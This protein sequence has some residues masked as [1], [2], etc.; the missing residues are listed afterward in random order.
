[1]LS[2]HS[3]AAYLAMSPSERLAITLNA[4]RRHDPCLLVG[5][6]EAHVDRKFE[7]IRR[8]NDARNANLI[9]AFKRSGD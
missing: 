3:I 1:M 9:A 6:S 2:Q 5:L 4:C 7:L 8:E